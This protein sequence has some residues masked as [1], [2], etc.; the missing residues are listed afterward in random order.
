MSDAKPQRI[1]ALAF[2]GVGAVAS[3]IGLWS[4]LTTRSFVS[5]AIPT[6]GTITGYERLVT[7][8]RDH[9]D[10]TIYLYAPQIRFVTADGQT[11]D[12]T[13]RQS[14][15][16]RGDVGA[17]VDVLYSPLDPHHAELDNVWSWMLAIFL[18]GF[19][20]CFL[21]VGCGFAISANRASRRRA[22]PFAMTD[23]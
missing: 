5:S 23:A 18:G 11:I 17:P 8:E 9:A 22:A 1:L 3:A 12:F 14:S 13:S 10:R 20:A 7:M 2:L 19:G 16:V 4:F 15:N 6:I 21:V